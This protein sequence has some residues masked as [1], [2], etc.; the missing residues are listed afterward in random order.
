MLV[1]FVSFDL[2]HINFYNAF[3]AQ[4]N[5]IA[6]TFLS[7]AWREYRPLNNTINISTL[8]D[9]RNITILSYSKIFMKSSFIFISVNII[10]K[11][12]IRYFFFEGVEG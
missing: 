12:F 7:Y 3:V 1:T 10:Q 2:S 4:G 6:F 8:N 5:S 9:E 11:Y